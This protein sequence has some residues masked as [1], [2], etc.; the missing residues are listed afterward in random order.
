MTPVD[1]NQV[2]LS[3]TATP[4]GAYLLQRSLDDMLSWQTIQTLTADTNGY[5]QWTDP[6]TYPSA[7]YRFCLP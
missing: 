6:G 2:Q 5:V 1:G 7:Y 3:M 4:G